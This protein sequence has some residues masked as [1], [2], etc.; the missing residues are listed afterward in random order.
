MG[1]KRRR[2][3][4]FPDGFAG[5]DLIMAGLFENPSFVHGLFENWL[6][7]E[8]SAALLA[9]AQSNEDRFFPSHVSC[10]G[11]PFADWRFALNIWLH[12]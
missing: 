7:P 3:D 2:A 11:I 10:S 9:Y 4:G 8:K 12:G 5:V 1:S 6:G